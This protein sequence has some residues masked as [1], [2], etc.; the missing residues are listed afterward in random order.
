MYYNKNM[1]IDR[2]WSKVLKT[3]TC[4][5]WIG[6]R[7]LD[8]YGVI[9][10]RKPKKHN[11]RAHRYSRELCNGP[12]PANLFICHSCDNPAC[13]NPSHLWAGTNQENVNDRTQKK[14]WRLTDQSFKLK[15]EDIALIRFYASHQI[16]SYNQLAQKFNTSSGYISDI[17]NR[18]TRTEY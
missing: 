15:K 16:Y 17:I 11:I 1:N 9:T 3:S 6:A 8:G 12:I 5:F 18:F 14:R 2:F 10:L 4:W 7:R 13:V